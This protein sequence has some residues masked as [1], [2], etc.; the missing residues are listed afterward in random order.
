MSLDNCYRRWFV[1][2]Q[3]AHDKVLASLERVPMESRSAPWFQ[4]SVDLFAHMMAARHMWLYRL[5]VKADRPLELFPSGAALTA[6]RP[7]ATTVQ[8]AWAAYLER[9]DERE[10]ARIFEYASTEGPR[11]RNRVED[12]LTQLFGHSS[13]HRGQIALLLR[14]GGAEPA[15]TDFVFWAREPLRDV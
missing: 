3:D 13:Y 8:S 11:Y 7:M 15:T 14:T 4:K 6:L 10:L 5:G 2:E 1:Y 9:L 12:I